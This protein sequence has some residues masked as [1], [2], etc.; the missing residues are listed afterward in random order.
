M[1]QI[2][3]AIPTAKEVAALDEARGLEEAIRADMAL[4]L[5]GDEDGLVGYWPLDMGARAVATDFTETAAHGFM[6][7]GVYWTAFA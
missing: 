4:P 2:L 1:Q 5:E 7:D 6:S 3:D